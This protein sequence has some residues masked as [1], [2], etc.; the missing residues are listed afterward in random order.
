MSDLMNSEIYGFDA[1][2]GIQANRE[3]YV[4]ICPM[5]IIPK[6]FVFNEYEIPAKLR[7]QRTL[8]E[9]R[10]PILTDYI[11]SNPDEYIF[12]SMQLLWPYVYVVHRLSKVLTTCL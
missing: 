2:R 12:P 9:S 5:K 11:L 4:V 10:I 1:I 3:Y 6:L 8:R 7:A